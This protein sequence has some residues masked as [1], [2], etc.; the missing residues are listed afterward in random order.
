M[1]LQ[2][3]GFLRVE[4]GVFGEGAVQEEMCPGG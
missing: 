2:G 1:Q 3:D 4:R